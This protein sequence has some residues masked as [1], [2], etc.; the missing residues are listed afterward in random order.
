LDVLPPQL[1]IGKRKQTSTSKKENA[2]SQRSRGKVPSRSTRNASNARVPAENTIRGDQSVGASGCA[3]G[4]N[5]VEEVVTITEAVPEAEE[6]KGGFTTQLVRRAGSEQVRSTR[7]LNPLSADTVRTLGKMAV[8]PVMTVCTVS[9][10]L[11]MEKS[12][13]MT[14]STLPEVGETGK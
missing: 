3:G 12:G 1:V 13:P 14:V 6:K 7:E 2:P 4:S 10:E 9:P 8:W 5:P 11:I